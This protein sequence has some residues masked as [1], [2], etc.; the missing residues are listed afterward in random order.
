MP[1]FSDPLILAAVSLFGIGLIAIAL[2]LW[3]ESN[4]RQRALDRISVIVEAR[5]RVQHLSMAGSEQS[6]SAL[7]GKLDSIGQ[8][9]GQTSFLKLLVEEEDIKLLGKAGFGGDQHINRYAVIRIAGLLLGIG[10]WFVITPP[11][12][13]LAASMLRLIAGIGL[14][15]MLP[16]W[17]LRGIANGRE[18]AF[19]KELSTTV[20]I[21]R[22]LQGVGLSTDQ[23]I[24]VMATQLSD[25][26]PVTGAIL[27][28]GRVQVQTGVPWL[29]VLKNINKVYDHPEFKSFV[30]VISQIDK[31]GGAVQEPLRQFSDR[32]IEKERANI[33]E[34]MGKLTVRISGIM[35]ATMMPSF[36]IVA[37]G[38]GFISLSRAF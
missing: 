20:D 33:K 14:C 38:P 34:N 35:V 32:L 5:R 4:R 15:F 16:K 37:A 1:D 26:I 18:M 28:K 6:T 17:I 25:L 27:Y 10:I 36:L 19:N 8:K 31:F 9:I 3:V 22:L 2:L 24:E 12:M 23:A 7:T 13:P 29:Q 30:A 11:G 21:M